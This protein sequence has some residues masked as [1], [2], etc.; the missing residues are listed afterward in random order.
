MARRCEICGKA[1]QYGHNVSHSKVRT[2]RRFLPNLQAGMV[3]ING[4]LVRATVCT[5]CLR[6]EGRV[7]TKGAGGA[8]A[9]GAV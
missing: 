6:S 7:T 9:T 8:R 1:P 5:R 4:K 2:N 3:T